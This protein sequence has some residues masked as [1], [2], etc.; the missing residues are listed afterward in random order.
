MVEPRLPAIAMTSPTPYLGSPLGVVPFYKT[1]MISLVD[2][3]VNRVSPAEVQGDQVEDV[4][5][6]IKSGW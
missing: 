1:P 2:T 6:Q 3:H 4:L 5:E